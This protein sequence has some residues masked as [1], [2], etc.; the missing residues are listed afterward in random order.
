M[1][2]FL[3][4]P[5]VAAGGAAGAFTVLLL[6]IL[7]TYAHVTPPAEVDLAIDVLVSVAAGYVTP[8]DGGK[9]A[10]VTVH[11]HFPQPPTD[12]GQRDAVES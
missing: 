1:P 10:A 5:K 7:A 2:P 6:W 9:S 8:A 3:L 11:Q 12:D 4:H